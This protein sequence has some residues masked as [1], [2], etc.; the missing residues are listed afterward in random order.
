M[1]S[2]L[3]RSSLQLLVYC[4]CCFDFV[5]GVGNNVPTVDFTCSLFLLP[6]VESESHETNESESHETLPLDL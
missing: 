4:L 5:V 1:T 2:G 3:D 6:E